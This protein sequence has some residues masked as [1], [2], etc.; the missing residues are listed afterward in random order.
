[1]SEKKEFEIVQHTTMNY[2][3]I[4]MV[5]MTARSPH[6]HDDLEIG[7]LLDG[8]L[9]MFTELEQYDLE[10]GDIYII[11]RYQIHSFLN[12][13]SENQILAF[14]MHTD[15][16]RRID[17]QLGFLR[18]VDGIIRNGELHDE[19]YKTLFECA[20][21]YF[22]ASAHNDIKCSSLL[23]DAIYQLLTSL[24]YTITSEKEST[25]AKNNSRRLNR[26]TDYI[27]EHYMEHI[28]LK[29]IADLEH[30]TTYHASHFITNMLGISFQEYLNNIRFEHAF[31]LIQKSDFSILD[32][33][34]ETGFSNSRYL[35]QMFVKNLGCN[36]KEYRKMQKKP[37]LIGAALPTDNIQ[38]R[39]SFEQ[40]AFEFERF[41]TS[42]SPSL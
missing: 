16:Y 8:K 24:P 3:E 13:G 4:F 25:A 31:Q 23:M 5:E 9:T 2:L 27:S 19:L 1:M 11:N 29:D 7:I 10:A 32:V 6:G 30:I 36:V 39:Y 22:S 42:F 37:H 18:F 38:K 14:R 15:F 34:L 21:C 33:C 35:N 20:A 41:K 40:A 28:S 26:I 17:Q 12:K